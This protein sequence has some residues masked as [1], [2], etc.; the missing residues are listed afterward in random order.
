V[1]WW[2]QHVC[3]LLPAAQTSVSRC[4]LLPC[5]TLHL[6]SNALTQCQADHHTV[7]LSLLLTSYGMHLQVNTACK[8]SGPLHCTYCAAA[9]GRSLVP[10]LD[11][12]P[13]CR[14]QHVFEAWEGCYALYSCAQLRTQCSTDQA[15]MAVSMMCVLQG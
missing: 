4:W 8:C 12:E 15:V 9:L 3:S 10:V 2:Q 1:S 7:L 14:H 11:T 5:T 6:C 13:Q